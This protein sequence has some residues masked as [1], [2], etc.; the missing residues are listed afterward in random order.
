MYTINRI[1]PAESIGIN[2][3]TIPS[4]RLHEHR[5]ARKFNWIIF[6]IICIVVIAA[7][8]TTTLLLTKTEREKASIMEMTTLTSILTSTKTTTTT[9]TTTSS[10]IE[11]TAI[12]ATTTTISSLSASSLLSSP[13]FS[14]L[15]PSKFSSFSSLILSLP[16]L[17]LAESTLPP[18]SSLFELLSSEQL[19][20]LV[21]LVSALSS[22]QKKIIIIIIIGS[23]STVQ[24]YLDYFLFLKRLFN[25]NDI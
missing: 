11:I 25:L 18:L 4:G 22:S 1:E 19:S 16:E 14:S 9:I 20:R 3:S 2:P 13:Q 24:I 12:A 15:S 8:V 23:I 7:V 6:I 21:T 5:R 17:T 10:S